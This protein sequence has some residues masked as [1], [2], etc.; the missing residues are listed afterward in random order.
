[1]YPIIYHGSEDSLDVDAYVI[2]P[3]E[4]PFNEAKKLCDSYKEINANLL[5]VKDGVVNWCYKGTVDECNNSMLNTYH[6]HKQNHPNPIK[7]KLE[8]SYSLK[9]VRT[10]RGLLSYHSR[11]DKRIEVKKALSS[12]DLSFKMEIL[13]S[14]DLTKVSDYEKNSLTEVYKFFA[15][16]LGQTYALLKDNVE[17]FTKKDVAQHYPKM[18]PYLKR[19]EGHPVNEL[20][21]FWAE[22]N[23]FVLANFNKVEKH[24]LF[25]TEFH[26]K[27]EVIDVKKEIVL[28]R[29]VVFDIDN[30]LMDETHRAKYRESGDWDTY[31]DLC[32]LDT[33]LKHIIKLTHEYK[34]KGYE[35]WVMSGRSESILDKTI[36]SLKE[37]N[38][39]FDNIKLRGLDNKMPDFVIK[40][41]WTRKL[42]G[43]ERIDY[44]YDDTDAVIEG[45]RKYGL[46]TIDVKE[47]HKKEKQLK[48]GVKF[49]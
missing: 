45:F 24:D 30:T 15:F 27:K 44:V 2:I 49:K 9:L 8:R 16:Q 42:I 36:A 23:S 46:N 38:V 26:G 39:Y 35:V 48:N 32:H 29:V 14:I 21:N 12:S 19:V 47:L 25:Y 5:S 43:I 22:F 37:H 10:I 20:Q 11:T 13:S 17:L 31:F 28:P 33:P 3:Q 40:P 6:L 1:M 18:A 41:A 34:N 4:L 7:N